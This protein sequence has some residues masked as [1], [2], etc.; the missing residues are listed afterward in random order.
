M[1]KKTTVLLC[2]VVAVITY[3]A[4]PW[5]EPYIAPQAAED[6]MADLGVIYDPTVQLENSIRNPV[7]IVPG[8]MGSTLEQTSKNRI[9]WGVFDSH[10][11]DPKVGSDIRLMACP[12]DG[13]DLNDFNDGIRPTGVLGAL[14]ISLAGLSFDL[15]AYS[16]ILR[17]LGVGGYRHEH[18]GRDTIDYEGHRS[19]SFQFPFDWRRDNAESARLLHEFL[20]E[21]KADIETE[22][23]RH[24]G[25]DEPVKF[26]I[27][28]HSMGG[29]VARYFLRYGDQGSAAGD[30]LELN[31]AG[32]EHVDRVILIAPPNNGSAKSFVSTHNGFKIGLD[33]FPSGLVATLPSI[34]QLLPNGPEPA[35]YDEETGRP[36]D[37]FDIETWDR[38]GWGMLNPD[39]DHVLQQLLPDVSSASKRREIAKTHVHACL[40]RAIA[41]QK[42][43]DVPAEP[44]QGTTLHLFAGDAIATVKTLHSNMKDRTL[45]P[46]SHA[47]GD[48]TITRQSALGDQRTS[49][50]W[51]PAV[52][53][54][55]SFDDVRFLSADHFGLTRSSGFTDNLLYLL[56]E[57]PTKNSPTKVVVPQEK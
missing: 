9:V 35:V 36:L 6:S 10:S 16:N 51:Y 32:C 52:K 23:K 22:R 39:Q 19:T 27:V 41:F 37:H 24:L 5:I 21:K 1:K 44:P 26:D 33:S 29:L 7:I 12:I 47:P 31:W 56:L 14:E 2:L 53:S 11:I 17:T 38:R 54:P 20:L 57:D 18:I 4:R 50:N 45:N 28:A 49:D 3:F 34:Y 8:M 43:L 55:V 46:R 42:A 13:T 40:D 25:I 15:N 48:S 30:A